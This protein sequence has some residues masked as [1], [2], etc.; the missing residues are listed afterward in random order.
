MIHPE[1]QTIITA[2]A[3][4]D[5]PLE[6]AIKNNACRVD[7]ETEGAAKAYIARCN[8]YRA[9]LRNICRKEKITDPRLEYGRVKLGLRYEGRKPH[10]LFEI[11]TIPVVRTL[12][13]EKLTPQI[14]PSEAEDSLSEIDALIASFNQIED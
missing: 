4:C 14:S 12:E 9:K 1:I 8:R 6:I 3:D 2:Y 5:Y 13:G 7:F 11:Y 10:V